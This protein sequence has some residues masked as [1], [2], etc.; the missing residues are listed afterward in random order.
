MVHGSKLVH[1]GAVMVLDTAQMSVVTSNLSVLL[2]A[3]GGLT[4]AAL[5]VTRRASTWRDPTTAALMGVG[6][7]L[8]GS[9]IG[10]G[11]VSAFELVGR[12]APTTLPWDGMPLLS[13]VGAFVAWDAVGYVYH[14]L[15]HRTRLGWAAHQPHHTGQTYDLTLAWR[16]SWLPVHGVVLP[17]VALGGWSLSTIVVCAALSNTLQAVQHLSAWHRAP[18][19][20]RAV[21]HTAVQH[22]HH[23]RSDQGSRFDRRQAVAVNLGP[24]FTV[25]DR[26]FGTYVDGTV[27][28]DAGYGV[29]GVRGDRLF[30]A[31]F[32]GW[33]AL[34]D[35][36]GQ[37]ASMAETESRR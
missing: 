23:H 31:Q 18:Q 35:R 26:L 17:L 4:E 19:S 10:V 25:W 13:F 12:F 24:V 16:Q 34:L 20:I 36:S 21:F 1:D 32:A 15:G 14:W 3:F 8:V 29:R 11:F 33:R 37:A 2:I 9:L 6:G 28:P 27:S 22:R 30:V 7:L 5:Q